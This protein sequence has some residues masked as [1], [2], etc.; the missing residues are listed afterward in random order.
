MDNLLTMI[1]FGFMIFGILIIYAALRQKNEY[2]TIN[3]ILGALFMLTAS[4][5][6][7]H[8]MKCY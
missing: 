6:I 7:K 4:Y 8:G 2:Y 5:V 1:G 3:L